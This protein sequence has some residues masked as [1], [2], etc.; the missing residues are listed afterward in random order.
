[1]RV[2]APTRADLPLL[3]ELFGELAEYENLAEELRAG[4]RLIGEALFGE[5]PQP[6]R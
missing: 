1:M 2:R 4:E 3:L 6:R 5:R